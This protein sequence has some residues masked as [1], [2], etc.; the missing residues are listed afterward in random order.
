M[1][2]RALQTPNDVNAGPHTAKAEPLNAGP[3]PDD[4]K[5]SMKAAPGFTE[6]MADGS[7][8]STPPAGSQ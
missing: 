1:Q 4:A 3:H 7:A 8:R 6:S 2:G 5:P